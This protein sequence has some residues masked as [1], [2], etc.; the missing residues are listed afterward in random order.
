MLKQSLLFSVGLSLT[1]FGVKAYVRLL[2]VITVLRKCR[3]VPIQQ[4]NRA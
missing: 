1:F 3:V 2:R 4:V